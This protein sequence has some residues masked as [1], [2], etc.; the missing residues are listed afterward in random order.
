VWEDVVEY[1][2]M[3]SYHPDLDKIRAV[4]RH[5]YEKPPD[6]DIIDTDYGKI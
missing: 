5:M 2:Q 4:L 3:L 1:V 6:L